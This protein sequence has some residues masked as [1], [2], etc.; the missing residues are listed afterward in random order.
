MLAHNWFELSVRGIHVAMVGAWL[1]FDF[2]VYWLHF[3]IKDA[4]APSMRGWNA[5]G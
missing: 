5:P 2:V 4:S 1:L 3:K